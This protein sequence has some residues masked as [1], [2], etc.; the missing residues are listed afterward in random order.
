MFTAGDEHI[1]KGM[2]R[3]GG[4]PVRKPGIR[5]VG[6]D[7]IHLPG[8]QQI[9]TAC[10]GLVGNLNVDAGM[11]PVKTVQIRNQEVA[12]DGIAGPDA[13]LAAAQSAGFHDLCLAPLDQIDSRFHVAQQNLAF[14]GQLYLFCAAD[15]EG[16]SQLLFQNLDRLAYC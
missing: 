13:D 10:G 12:A 8:F 3:D 15:K 9:H 4:H 1:P 11:L 5:V 14:R 2:D 6:D 7:K 16:D